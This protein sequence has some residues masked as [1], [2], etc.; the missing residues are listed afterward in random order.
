MRDGDITINEAFAFVL[1]VLTGKGCRFETGLVESGDD[2]ELELE[3]KMNR[4][5]V[6]GHDCA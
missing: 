6:V 1:P 2:L 4:I 5:V 3:R